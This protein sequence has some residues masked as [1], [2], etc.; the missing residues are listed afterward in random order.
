MK[1]I[2]LIK[3]FQDVDELPEDNLQSVSLRAY[4]SLT[5]ANAM[6]EK[7]KNYVFPYD[8]IGNDEYILM[9]K[10]IEKW[11]TKIVPL[12]SQGTETNGDYFWQIGVHSRIEIQENNMSID[13]ELIHRTKE[14]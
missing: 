10:I 5:L 14:D 1:L 8:E 2:D 6:L 4:M 13:T 9:Q 12:I 11:N 3:E 7:L